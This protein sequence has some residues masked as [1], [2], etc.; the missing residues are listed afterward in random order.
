M[1][2]FLRDGWLEHVTATNDN[3]A[4]QDFGGGPV[5]A[6]AV[7]QLPLDL[8]HPVQ[9]S[10]HG[11][12]LD[13]EAIHQSVVFLLGLNEFGGQVFV[14]KAATINAL[15]KSFEVLTRVMADWNPSS[16]LAMSS[17]ADTNWIST[18]AMHESTLIKR[19]LWLFNILTN[20]V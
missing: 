5:L 20:S 15:V 7:T 9:Q 17:L 16:I 13:L 11:G 12:L 10:N 1:E 19:S 8:R 2:R 6:L 3:R 18:L 4:S 14:L